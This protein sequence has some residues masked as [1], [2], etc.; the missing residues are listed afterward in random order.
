M[1]RLISEG[2]HHQNRKSTTKQAIA[3]LIRIHSTR[4]CYTYC[5]FLSSN[6]VINK[7][8]SFLIWSDFWLG[9]TLLHG[10]LVPLAIE[11]RIIG[12][13]PPGRP[14]VGILDRVKDARQ[15]LCNGQEVRLRTRT[16]RKDLPVGRTHANTHT[17]FWSIHL[18]GGLYSGGL[19]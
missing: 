8:N 15:P 3:V 19:L 13:G 5:F 7:L 12:K 17:H 11:G 10:D 6:V 18:E 2:G 9:H 16:I 4:T 1:E 14:R